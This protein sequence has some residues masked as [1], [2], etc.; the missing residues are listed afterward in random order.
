MTALPS[1]AATDTASAPRWTRDIAALGAGSDAL[2]LLTEP[3]LLTERIRG[4]CGG[5]FGLRIVT[6][7]YGL[8]SPP[9][10]MTLGVTDLSAFIREIELTCAAAAVVFAQTLVPAATLTAEPW[11]SALG[12]DALGPRLASL[13][14]ALREPLEFARLAP[15]HELTRRALREAAPVPGCLWARRARY[16]LATHCLVVQEVFLPGAFA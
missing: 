2:S 10:A 7:R 8:L 3:G 5:E 15:D 12:R 14:G 13:G 6:E 9:D 1:I 4:A 16:R 11:L